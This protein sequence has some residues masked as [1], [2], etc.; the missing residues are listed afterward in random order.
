MA[1]PRATTTIALLC[2]SLIGVLVLTGWEEATTAQQSGGT[3][4]FLRNG[5][6]WLIRPDASAARRLP[7]K[8]VVL[9]PRWSPNAKRIAFAATRRGIGKERAYE[10]DEVFVVNVDGSGARR[11]TRTRAASGRV[12]H[13]HLSWSP[14]GRKIVF[15]KNDDGAAGIHVIGVDGR[16][17]RTLIPPHKSGWL[18]PRNSALS[19]DGRK[20]ALTDGDSVFVVNAG[21]GR[22]PRPVA[23]VEGSDLAWSADG[24]KI[25][26]LGDDLLVMNRDGSELRNVT[27][28]PEAWEIDGLG[29]AWSPNGRAIAVSIRQQSLGDSQIWLVNAD[30]S[31]KRKLTA[32]AGGSWSPSWSPSG[33][34]I[35]FTSARDGNSEIYV[36]NADGSE[37]RRLTH[38]QADDSSP[39][40]SPAR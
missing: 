27:Q 40:W 21:G 23:R 4:A 13:D 7:P 29:F 26:V 39:A 22:R 25:A 3:I 10:H 1:S 8:R 14:G 28:L 36:M 5:R 9:Q 18:A 32:A 19:P 20:L 2:A 12:F 17:R 38:S 35:A 6:I 33:N 24:R 37:Q 15:D 34:R 11:L 31:G 16:G 30:G